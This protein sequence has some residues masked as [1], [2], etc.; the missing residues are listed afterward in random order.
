MGTSKPLPCHRLCRSLSAATYPVKRPIL[1]SAHVPGGSQ[2]W[3]PV[4]PAAALPN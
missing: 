4:E 2:V 3:A 1:Q